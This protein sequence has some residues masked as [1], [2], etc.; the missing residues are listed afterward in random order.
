MLF[1][2]IISLAFCNISNNEKNALI[3]IYIATNGENWTI[4]WDIN[5]QVSTWNGVEVENDM[6]VSLDLSFNN[7]EG[8][9]P[10]EI[11]NLINLRSQK[12]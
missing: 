9:L 4:T 7:L 5:A 11:G 10:E 3:V 6:V 1:W 2:L 12:L 8:E